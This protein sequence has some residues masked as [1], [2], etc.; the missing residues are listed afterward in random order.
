MLEFVF[1]AK[2]IKK[3]PV[4]AFFS[5]AIITL[6]SFV[7]SLFIFPLAAGLMT[8]FFVTMTI[9]PFATKVFIKNE[10]LEKQKDKPGFFARHEFVLKTYT[11]FFL[12]VVFGLSFLFHVM[13][14]PEAE[15]AFSYQMQAMS[16]VNLRSTSPGDFYI[17]LAN[18]LKV[19]AISFL[20]SVLFG[21]GAILVLS[22]NASI[23]AV[24]I[25]GISKGFIP[26]YSS[27]GAAAVPLSYAH[28]LPIAILSI[29]LHGIPEIT[30]YFLSGLAGGL[31]SVALIREKVWSPEFNRV[32]KD[33][34]AL[35]ATS[36]ALIVVA[37]FLESPPL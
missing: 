12:A 13:P 23:I 24:F 32:A 8:V 27:L 34:L 35:L 11:L 17:V 5:G 14:A 7:I 28:G 1:S 26:V 31:I 19:S 10:F 18:N 30:S 29:F 16:E 4:C 25:G 9:V 36:L 37:A 21:A 15:K 22:W 20:L 3:N 33:G 6:V 2:N